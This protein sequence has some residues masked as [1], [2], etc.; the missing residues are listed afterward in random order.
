MGP[1]S[2][3]L[4]SL[5]SSKPRLPHPS[6]LLPL[7]GQPTGLASCQAPSPVTQVSNLLSS[8]HTPS[9]PQH[10]HCC[11]LFRSTSDRSRGPHGGVE[12]RSEGVFV[13]WV[14]GRLQEAQATPSRGLEGPLL[15]LCLKNLQV[16][17][18]GFLVL[19][20]HQCTRDPVYQGKLRSFRKLFVVPPTPSPWSRWGCVMSV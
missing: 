13:A 6:C 11:S 14:L 1:C 4:C 17:C 10:L 8:Q 16:S 2:H 15:S 12:G 18:D 9:L 19:D 7:L 3:L 5:F 20:L